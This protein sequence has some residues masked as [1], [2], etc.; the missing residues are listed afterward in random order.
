MMNSKDS[1]GD[2]PIVMCIK[3]GVRFAPAYVNRLYAGVRRNLHIPFRFICFT[4]NGEGLAD[5]IEIFPLPDLGVPHPVGVPG[6]WPKTALWNRDLFGL[7]GMA[8]FLDLDSVIVGDLEPFFRYGNPE[9]VVVARNWLKPFQ[10]KGQTT[11]FRFPVGK[12]GYMLDDFR[13]N[14]QRIAEK[15]QFEQHYV[16]DCIRPGIRFWP[17]KWVRH[18]RFHC[19]GKNY[20]MRY[21]RPAKIPKGTRVVAFPG[22]PNP[23]ESEL[24]I[25][26]PGQTPVAPWQHFKNAFSKSS[27]RE[28]SPIRHLKFYQLPCPWIPKYWRE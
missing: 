13:A 3:W 14:P 7:S 10:G 25:W 16:T 20:L 17:E 27:R 1:S 28:S 21:F 4:D 12:H 18:Y 6:K 26:R 15:Y 5:G 9:D 19:L 11:L 23:A 8:L 22:L 24:G 2:K